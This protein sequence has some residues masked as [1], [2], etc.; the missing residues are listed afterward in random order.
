[1]K[2]LSFRTIGVL[3]VLVMVLV[4]AGCG[5]GGG[6]G[7]GGATT[8]DGYE[9]FIV[10]I[11]MVT[12]SDHPSTVSAHMFSDMMYERSNGRL[13]V[14]VYS[15]GA[16]GGDR[17]LIESAALGILEIAMVGEAGMSNVVP[18][19]GVITLPYLFD[20][21]EAAMAA[22]HGQ[23]G[24]HLEELATAQ[25]LHV[26]GWGGAGFRNL[27]TTS[28]EV[29]TPA[30]LSGLMI[31]T[32]EIPMHIDLWRALGANPTPMAFTELF[33]GL[34]QGTV[35]GQENPIVI[36]QTTGF[37]EVQRYFILTEHVFSC[38]PI[39]INIPFLNSLPADLRQ[40][41]I[42]GGREWAEIQRQLIL[43]NEANSLQIIKDAG[44]V[45]IELTP[46]EKQAFI[47]AALTIYDSI[48]EEFGRELVELA[49]SYNQR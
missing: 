13:I 27:S 35:D 45:V 31:R 2:K 29:R 15:D 19:F 17:Q 9:T 40:L 41:I 20:S 11:G 21:Y 43:D 44:M 48:Y 7:G 42:D 32:Q 28:R 25:N 16:L 12:A 34:Q 10:R 33:M 36:F 38:A 37:H 46:A 39:S 26:L 1:M 47:D 18:E 3:L 4:T 49:R 5:G 8:D 14:Q 30:D 24:A 6:G 22:L 23:L